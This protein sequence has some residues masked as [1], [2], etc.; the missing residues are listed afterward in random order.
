MNYDTQLLLPVLRK[1]VAANPEWSDQVD[2]VS[3]SASDEATRAAMTWSL[4]QA[5]EHQDPDCRAYWMAVDKS[6]FG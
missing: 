4:R 1:F 6:V 3:G 2:L 5:L